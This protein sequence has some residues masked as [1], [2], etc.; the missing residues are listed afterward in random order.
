MF[1]NIPRSALYSAIR[2]LSLV[3]LVFASAL[4][5]D[6]Y[7][8]ANTFCNEGASCE[9]VAKSEF[10]QKYGIFLPTLGL[11]A[12]SFFFLTSF[13]FAKTKRK[14]FG[15]RLSS[16]WLPLA[17]ICCALGAFLFIIVQATEIHAFCYLCMGIDTSAILMVIP[18]VLLMIGKNDKDET[19]ASFFHPVLWIG[20]YLLAAF[21]PLT[22]G[23]F[24]PAAVQSEAPE[25][26]Q[27][28]YR[29]GKINVVE[30]SSF[31]CPHCRQLHPEFSKLLESYGD[32]INF[33]RLTIP[34]GSRKEACIAYYCAEIQKKQNAF[35]ECMFE[36]PSKDADRLLAHAKDC[37]IDEETFKSC[38]DDPKSREAV[39]EQLKNIESTGFK[40]APTVWIEDTEIIGY[41]ASLGMTPYKDAIDRREVSLHAKYPLAFIATLAVSG[42]LLLIGGFFTMMR[43]NNAKRDEDK[44]EKSNSEDKTE[45]NAETDHSSDGDAPETGGGSPE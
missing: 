11:L 28:F 24:Q 4:A 14:L 25:Y 27:S 5:V 45:D 40:G 26:V 22:W 7:F 15:K 36:D 6:Y 29:P 18:A 32:K 19:H 8:N 37:S 35:A 41:N 42:I 30:I 33:T 43:H 20:L 10:G 34:L 13:F 38:L 39:D 3:A 9:I 23:T 2:L 21:G 16:F 1:R 44:A 31:D 17:V 12:Y